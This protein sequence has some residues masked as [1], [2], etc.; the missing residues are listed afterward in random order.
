[1]TTQQLHDIMWNKTWVKW[2]IV[3]EKALISAK[4]LE[5]SSKIKTVQKVLWTQQEKLSLGNMGNY[6][7]SSQKK[8]KDNVSEKSEEWVTIINILIYLYSCSYQ[9]PFA[10]L[11]LNF[12]SILIKVAGSREHVD[13]RRLAAVPHGTNILRLLLLVIREIDEN[14]FSL[15]FALDG[16]FKF[17]S[18]Q[19]LWSVIINYTQHTVQSSR[20]ISCIEY[21]NENYLS[22]FRQL[23]LKK[24]IRVLWQ[25]QAVTFI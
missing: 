10:P 15:I 3:I 11:F 14:S 19:R 12:K 16:F 5:A 13:I 24:V 25:M 1:M 9:K 8:D 6:C 2:K 23:L 22:N 20:K 7:S 21:R 4:I 17:L 18:K